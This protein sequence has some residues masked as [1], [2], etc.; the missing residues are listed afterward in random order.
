[1]LTCDGCQKTF[2][3]RGLLFLH[4]SNNNDCGNG[5]TEQ[6]KEEN[7]EI[8]VMDISTATELQAENGLPTD[9]EDLVSVYKIII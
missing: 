4:K 7:C 8:E 9:F 3:S 6:S 2:F 1:M 5:R